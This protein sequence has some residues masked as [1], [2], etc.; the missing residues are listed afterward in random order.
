MFLADLKSS[1]LQPFRTFALNVRTYT[2]PTGYA[3]QM[4]ELQ[5]AARREAALPEVRRVVGDSTVDVF[6]QDQVYALFNELNYHPRPVFQS[7]M[8][9]NSRLMGLNEDFY[10]SKAAP[11][12]VLFELAAIDRKFPPL[13][14][15]CVLRDLLMNYEPGISER[16]FLLLHR[17]S[18]VTPQLSLLHEGTV[19]L[20]ESIALGPDEESALWLEIQVRPT[21]RGWLRRVLFKP[22]KIRVVAWSDISKS[23][24]LVRSPA[25]VP[26]LAA[27][28][29]ASPLLLTSEDVL[30]FRSGSFTRPRA[31]SIECEED[32]K[33]FW[34]DQA[35]FQLYKI[36]NF[37]LNAPK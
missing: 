3:K 13:E 30:K 11:H 8:A 21:R 26:T 31:Y 10:L 2:D 17:K 9:Y 15:A 32:D 12:Y 35:N 18:S 25:S 29:L 19:R 14:D 37:T 22:P 16:H 24:R 1:L 7:Y 28:F 23:R 27:G 34:E 5:A 33:P 20:G 4:L 6:G 36:E